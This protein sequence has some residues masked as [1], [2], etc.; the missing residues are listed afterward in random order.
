MI[1]HSPHIPAG[2]PAEKGD[3]PPERLT[4]KEQLL[5]TV[6]VGAWLGCTVLVAWAYRISG[7]D[8]CWWRYH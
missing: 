2:Q 6:F 5:L 1:D 7:G 3:A 8:L 4:F